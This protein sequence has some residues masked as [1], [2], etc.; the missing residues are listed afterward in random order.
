MDPAICR[1]L[2]YLEVKL[3][4][5]PLESLG[6]A[7]VLRFPTGRPAHDE[8]LNLILVVML[9]MGSQFK[10]EGLDI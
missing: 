4:R 6:E 3:G 7:G 8:M 5:K 9:V 2:K 1:I 10:N